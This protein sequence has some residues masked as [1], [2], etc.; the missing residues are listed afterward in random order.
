MNIEINKVK[1]IVTIPIENVDEVRNA[2]CEAGAG[3][4]G[5][6]THCSMSTKCV[7]TFEPTDEANP[8]IGERNNLE[9][10]EEEKLEVVCDV[11]I[12]K[13]V[14]SKL[15]EV[16]PYEEPAIDIIPLIDENFFD[17]GE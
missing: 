3:V 11:N 4:I 6:Y 12:V 17:K 16:H 9:F 2:I 15:R 13:N 7:G 5:N 8:Y 10:V 1:I 14:I